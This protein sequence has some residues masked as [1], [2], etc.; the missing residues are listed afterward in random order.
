[1]DALPIDRHLAALSEALGRT[2]ACVLSAEPGAGKTTRVP[3]AL[4]A[5]DWAAGRAV[6][7]LEPRRL[8]AL[9]AAAR[10]AEE[11]G[12]G[13]PGGFVGYHFRFDRRESARTRVLFLTDGMFLKRLQAD[14]DLD[15]VACVVLDEFHERSLEADLS[16]ALVRRLRLRRPDLRLLVMS[17]TLD[18]GTL[19]GAL[20]APVFE[21]PGRVHPVALSYLDP[22][23]GDPEEPVE[24]GMARALRCVMDDPGDILAFLPGVGEI[25]RVAARIAGDPAF[26]GRRVLQ[27]HGRLSPEEQRRILGTADRPKIIL[28]TNVAETSLT[29]PGV[30]VVVDS[31]LTRRDAYNPFSGL[32]ALVTLP[33][34]RASM[35]QRSGRAGRE[36]PGRC[37]RLGSPAEFKARPPFD[38]PEVARADL[39]GAVLASLAAGY[40]DPAELPWLQ[41]PPAAH[42][43]AAH[44]TLRFLGAL[45][46]AGALTPKGRALARAPLHPRLAALAW[47]ARAGSK[48]E[49]DSLMACLH[50]LSEGR[51]REP[52]FMAALERFRPEDGDRRLL[53]QAGAWLDSERER[54][55]ASAGEWRDRLTLALL[56]AFPEQAA[57]TR[58]GTDRRGEA[59]FLLASGREALG[60]WEG[61]R[62]PP[63]MYLLV[64][65]LE[66]RD[67]GGSAGFPRVQSLLPLEPEMLVEAC[68]QWVRAELSVAFD[69][70][71]GRVQ[72]RELLRFG[73]L[74]LEERDAR[75]P[76]AAAEAA[77]VVLKEARKAGLAAFCGE[78]QPERYLAR[79]EFVLARRPE[80]AVGLPDEAALWG[81]LEELA[82]GGALSFEALRQADP[83]RLA[84]DRAPGA[85]VLLE[86]GAPARLRL[87]SGREVTVHYEPGHDPWVAGRIQDFFGTSRTPRVAG[88]PVTVRLLAPNQRP[89]QVTQD[90]AGFWEREYPRLRRELMRRYPRHAW[91]EDP[92]G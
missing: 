51:L 39:T 15:S 57:S 47:E 11:G 4:C 8:A 76:E 53:E 86:E 85:R 23:G 33:A 45:D 74:T 63:G 28:A 78:G 92:L 54:P 48:R 41:A 91:P 9:V 44:A 67:A 87:D 49:W 26:D 3:P 16:L 13:E 1:M 80:E 72:A 77:A 64:E 79:R 75:G 27:L 7:V 6:W 65:L 25:R 56:K 24:R 42:L 43:E 55:A 21:V 14:P 18:T 36:A 82:V 58:Q 66:R 84:L 30:R 17:A 20:G 37:L 81:L 12:H 60:R 10:V 52:D 68:P 90:L 61:H 62:V 38:E 71:S 88:R 73:A 40:G 69:P 83:L 46:G 70:G 32:A 2:G 22:A 29:V 35:A 19:A 5:A 59:R 34:S 50:L 89:Q 31:G